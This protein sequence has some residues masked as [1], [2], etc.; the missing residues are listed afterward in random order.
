MTQSLESSFGDLKWFSVVCKYFISAEVELWR[1]SGVH[2]LIQ[3]EFF[4]MR[5]PK[6]RE[7]FITK[8]KKNPSL[9]G[10]WLRIKILKEN[11]A[12]G[13]YQPLYSGNAQILLFLA[14]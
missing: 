6:Y 10:K 12:Y 13:V 7:K 2:L 14:T 1:L 4:W 3:G 9:P 11:L 5:I 8:L